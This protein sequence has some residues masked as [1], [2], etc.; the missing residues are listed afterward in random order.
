MIV[1]FFSSLLGRRSTTMFFTHLAIIFYFSQ[2]ASSDTSKWDFCITKD[3]KNFIKK[4]KELT[5]LFGD[6]E[7]SK[8]LSIDASCPT[9]FEISV[10]VTFDLM[11]LIVF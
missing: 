6:Y 4:M 7:Q 9:T 1:S 11:S 3:E 5:N 2:E 10:I 8:K